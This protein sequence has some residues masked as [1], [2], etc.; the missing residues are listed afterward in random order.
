MEGT[1]FT[2]F[3][4]VLYKGTEYP[5]IRIT[6][7]SDKSITVDVEKVGKS[8]IRMFSLQLVNGEYVGYTEP[9]ARLI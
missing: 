6:E 3:T 1:Q 4:S 9:L 5:I 8:P 7:N 2:Q